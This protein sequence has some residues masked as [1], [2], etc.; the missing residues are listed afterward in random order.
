MGRSKGE[1]PATRKL[2]I[3][4]PANHPVFALPERERSRVVREWLDRGRDM[5]AALVEVRRE[6]EK[7]R[8]AMDGIR[9]QPAPPR[10]PDDEG[11]RREETRGAAV[12]DAAAFLDI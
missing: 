5:A 11:V 10:G 6:I 8:R 1:I 2:T 12:I 4:L 7:L 9:G 3:R